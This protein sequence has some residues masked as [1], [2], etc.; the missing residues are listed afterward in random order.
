MPDG[1]WVVYA[2]EEECCSTNFPTSTTCYIE[3]EPAQPTK[4]PTIS[5]ED[6]DGQEIIP[7]Q[8]VAIGIPDDASIGEVK[9]E[10]LSA[11]KRILLQ[12]SERIE[13]LKVKNV[14]EKIMR[15]T[16]NLSKQKETK[17]MMMLMMPLRT[18]NHPNH[19]RALEQ[20]IEIYFD[21]SVVYNDD[22]QFGPII[23]E[24]IRDSYDEIISQ[25]Q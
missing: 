14:E 23:I 10:M 3:M 21:V 8:F 5:L 2:S 16:R 25:I 18:S 24:A 17:K 1:L 7:I 13:E 20:N 15:K 4:H 11:L 9:A 22:I 12:L 19:P 6:E